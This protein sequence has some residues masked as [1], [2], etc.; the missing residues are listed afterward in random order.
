PLTLN[1][2]QVK[3]GTYSAPIHMVSNVNGVQSVT[4]QVPFEV[5]VGTTN[6]TIT[7]SGGTGTVSGV[8]VKPVQP[9]LLETLDTNGRYIAVLSRPDGSAVTTSNPAIHG[10]IL[11]MYVIGLGQTSPLAATNQMGIPNQTVIT[12]LIAG[13]AGGGATVTNTE[14]ATGTIGVYIVS[15]QLPPETAP[16]PNVAISIAV[17]NPN[18]SYEGSN[19]AVIAAVI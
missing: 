6:V 15:F 16:G 11:R 9:G 1:G 13:I 7:L 4:V 8:Q 12:P 18:G 2:V 14:Y 3:F 17:Q 19:T 10:E 5:P